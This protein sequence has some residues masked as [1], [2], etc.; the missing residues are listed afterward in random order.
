MTDPLLEAARQAQELDRDAEADVLL[1]QAERREPNDPRVHLMRA[2]LAE[3][4]RDWEQARV[5]LQRAFEID[6]DVPLV[7]YRLGV[8]NRRLG[9]RSAAVFHLEGA[10]SGFRPGTAAR[11]RAE[12]EIQR[13]TF[14]VLDESGLRGERDGRIRHQFTRGETVVWWGE[15][16]KRFMRDNPEFE[17]HWIRPD[18]QI[19]RRTVI[20]MGGMGRVSSRFDSAQAQIG[21]WAVEVFAADSPVGW[22]EFQIVP[23]GPA[24]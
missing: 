1:A 20:R 19:E 21:K 10:A 12:F 22:E 15:V 11:K 24:N 7:Q 4:R 6:P 23:D 17:V 5:H 8:V 2:D 3:N 18:G 13:L 9:N 16:S 14:D